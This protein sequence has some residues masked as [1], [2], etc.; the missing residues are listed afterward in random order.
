MTILHEY[1]I[2]GLALSFL[3]NK[4]EKA[5]W[6]YCLEGNTGEVFALV[7]WFG[8][9]MG[10]GGLAQAIYNPI[11]RGEESTPIGYMRNLDKV[12]PYKYE[13]QRSKRFL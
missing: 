13:T 1:T 9:G 3:S 11:S 8:K 7:D 12:K 2:K 6:W 4:W 5:H 10:T